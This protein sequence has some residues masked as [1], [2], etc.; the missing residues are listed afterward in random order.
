MPPQNTCPECGSPLPSGAPHGLC[1]RCLLSRAAAAEPAGGGRGEVHAEQHVSAVAEFSSFHSPPM[2]LER[3]G[4]RIGRY[5]LLQKIGEGGCGIVYMAEQQEPVKRRVALK[6]IKLGMDTKEVIARFEAERQALALMDHE[7]IA[8]VLDGGATSSGRPFF[9][10]ELVRGI[11]ITQ[12]CDEHRLNTK[13]RLELFIRVCHAIQHAHQK[14]IIHRDLK[15]SNILVADHDGTPIPKV[16]DFGIAKATAGQTLTD[17]T[18]FTAFEQFIGTPTYMSPEQAKLSGLDV[19][20]RSDIYSLGVLL[21]ELLTGKTPFDSKRLTR[22]GFDEVRRIIQEE[23]PPRPSTLLGTLSVKEQTS[24][25]HQR[26]SEV[27]KLLVGLRGDLDWIIMKALDKDRTRRYDTATGLA[28]DLQRHL[29]CEPILARPPSRLYEFQKTVR[30]HK[31]GF[32]A[33][34]AVMLTLMAGMLLSGLEAARAR[35]AERQQTLLRLGEQQARQKAERNELLARQRAYAADMNL[36]Q[37]AGNNFGLANDLLERQLP[38]PGQ[39]DLRGWEWRYAWQQC[40]SDSIFELCRRSNSI[41]CLAVSS[42]GRWLAVGEHSEGGLSVWDI[43]RRKQIAQLQA[44]EH[45]V[46]CSYVPHQA[47]LAFTSTKWKSPTEAQSRIR[48]WDCEA[49]REIGEGIP[50]EAYCRGLA[51]SGDGRVLCTFTEDDR[52]TLWRLPEGTRLASYPAALQHGLDPPLPTAMTPDAKI[53]AYTAPGGW[54]NL[55]D[56]VTGHERWAAKAGDEFIWGLAI[57]KDGTKL[58]TV[59]HSIR[60]WNT[61]SGTEIA[62]SEINSG[63]NPVFWNSGSRLASV[64]E[65]QALQLWDISDSAKLRPEGRPLHGPRTDVWC[66]ALLP[67][68]STLVTGSKDGSV[69]LWDV[70]SVRQESET[71]T[72]P[73]L[74]HTWRFSSDSR[75]LIALDQLG[76]VSKWEGNGYQDQHILFSVGTNILQANFS[77]D[78]RFLVVAPTNGWLEVWDVMRG[79]IV[80]Q[81]ACTTKRMTFN[82]PGLL[83]LDSG[84]KLLVLDEENQLHEWDLLSRRDLRSWPAPHWA[85]TVALSPDERACLSLGR[86]G[87]HCPASINDLYGQEHRE[88]DLNLACAEDVCFSPDGKLFAVAS[89]FG[90]AK[91]WTSSTLQEAVVLPSSTML[92]PEFSVCFSSDGKRL[93]V[94]GGGGVAVQLYDTESGQQLFALSGEGSMF[95]PTAFSPDGNILAAMNYHGQVFI[96]KAPSWEEIAARERGGTAR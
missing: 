87:S 61:S 24:I 74:V 3:P 52:V 68:Q 57:S 84:K 20:T 90:G 72:L 4:D 36:I 69:Q 86:L 64:R 41:I 58:A 67:D 40:Q 46:Y 77:A 56:L 70:S 83:F 88:S 17:K 7:N 73:A 48:F 93:A 51:I 43:R 22:A 31:F 6:V 62:H 49:G 55:L 10:M 89:S 12:Y 91:M 38:G 2:A 53:A 94:G 11:S 27:G 8:K 85:I 25:A 32:G 42:N 23:D 14:G 35:R 92:T 37:S 18:L 82:S 47:L 33:A 54:V 95:W 16:I 79:K 44:G 60:L 1:P 80:S 96:W 5:K 78:A 26:Q 30:R 13:H 21:Y 71:A 34:A 39:E 65:N 81:L 59:E 66:L 45:E 76:R 15:P 75:A 19:D 29:N 9:V 63:G 28:R 50:L